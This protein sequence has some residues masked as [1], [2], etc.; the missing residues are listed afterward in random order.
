MELFALLFSIQ[1]AMTTNGQTT[2]F[3]HLH[4]KGNFRNTGFGFSCLKQ[5]YAMHIAGNLRYISE[6]EVEMNLEGNNKQLIRFF[7][8]CKSS[9][10]TTSICVSEPM[11]HL[12]GLKDF[13]IINSL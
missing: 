3:H 8:W 7:S 2:L 10:E 12:L 1:S 5:A 6:K 11:D 13:N 9:P 4:L